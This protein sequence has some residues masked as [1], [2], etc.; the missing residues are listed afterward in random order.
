MGYSPEDIA[1]L[2]AEEQET[3]AALGEESDL[4]VDGVEG[5]SEDG[6]AGLDQTTDQAPDPGLE[7][8]PGPAKQQAV[9]GPS[10]DADPIA[11]LEAEKQNLRAQ[12]DVGDIGSSVELYALTDKID[13]EIRAI[14]RRMDAAQRNAESREADT[15][16]KWDAAV[17]VF[18]IDKAE[19]QTKPTQLAALGSALKSVANDPESSGKGF[20]E[21]LAA[22]DDMVRA[23][24]GLPAR[25][26]KVVGKP[27]ARREVPPNIG[28]M[29]S[30]IVAGT[31][32]DSKFAVLDK[33]L[34]SDP[35]RYEAQ[36]GNLT[37]SEREAYLK[38]E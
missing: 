38:R 13:R 8:E 28:R 6:S 10:V 14:E 5:A 35:E 11:A 4:A 18:M 16:S 2:T 27:Q 7:S 19:Y 23:D 15:K 30:A 24:F 22:A 32:G 29:P 34:T 17:G 33:L 12:F 31:E 1:F 26:A 25:S 3:L 36:Y 37:A 21:L 9:V 20:A